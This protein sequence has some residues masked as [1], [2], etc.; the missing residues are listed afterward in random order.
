MY[1]INSTRQ[2]YQETCP[3]WDTQ[4]D[5]HAQAILA[6][7]NKLYIAESDV[8]AFTQ[9][10]GAQ[11]AQYEQCRQMLEDAQ[12]QLHTSK[13][14]CRAKLKVAFLRAQLDC[15]DLEGRILAH[16]L[17]AMQQTAAAAQAELDNLAKPKDKKDKPVTEDK[18]QSK[19]TQKKKQ[20][21]TPKDKQLKS[22]DYQYKT[23]SAI[24]KL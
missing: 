17:T 23:K 24:K 16:D 8:E 9:R 19:K 21:K 22:T 1:S 4:R 20:Q 3:P 14:P 11:S 5:E 7:R 18:T 6:A 10:I 13:D 2:I 12:A 15:C